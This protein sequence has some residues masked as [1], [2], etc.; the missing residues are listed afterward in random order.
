MPH[1]D[2]G[3]QTNYQRRSCRQGHAQ[4]QCQPAK[5]RRQIFENGTG[6]DRLQFFCHCVMEER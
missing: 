2:D 4:V 5:P 1:G 6:F 3:Q